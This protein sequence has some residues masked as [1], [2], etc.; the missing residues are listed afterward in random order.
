MRPARADVAAHV[1]ETLNTYLAG[2]RGAFTAPALDSTSAGCVSCHP[3]GKLVTEVQ[4]AAPVA[5]GME[6]ATCHPTNTAPHW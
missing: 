6:C 2:A 5:S 1:A 3:K 4:R